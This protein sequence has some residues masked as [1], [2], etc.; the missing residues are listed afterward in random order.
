VSRILVCPTGHAEAVARGWNPS[1]IVGFA[2]P[3]P[4][5]RHGNRLLPTS[6]FFGA[7]A[8]TNRLASRGEGE[9]EAAELRLVFNDIAE[10][11]AG[12]VAPSRADIAA[13]LAFGAGWD[14][15]HPFLVH[16]SMGISRSTAAALILA[17]AARPDIPEARL[18][19]ALR[20]AAPCATPNPLMIALADGL[21]GRDGRL[22]AAV[23]AIGRGADYRPYRM[24]SLDLAAIS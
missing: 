17:A 8:G 13:L 9:A 2:A 10:P 20:A 19:G 16:C 15:A 23:R 7:P 4:P 24:V 3:A 11:Q 21:L 5:S 6:I 14:G 1:H 22:V 18:A 12:L